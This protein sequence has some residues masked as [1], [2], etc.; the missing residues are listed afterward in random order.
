M[1]LE[2][3]LTRLAWL[4]LVLLLVAGC[5]SQQGLL[6]HD[7]FGNPDSGWGDDSQEMFDR[8]YEDGEY[9]IEVYETDWLAWAT[10]GERLGDIVVQ[11]DARL[12]SGPA[13]GSLGLLC[14][15]NDPDSFYYFAITDDGYAAILLVE[16]GQ[17]ENLS[18]GFVSAAAIQTGGATNRIRAVCAGD[19]LTMYVNDEQVAAAIDGTFRRG[20]VGLAVSSGPEGDV[21]VHFDNLTVRAAQE[22]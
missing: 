6:Y 16:E 18:G 15:Y 9:F 14:R 19:R 12:V 17:V 21:R 22:E 3:T 7:R 20:D 11:A 2:R 13:D 5:S 8:G 1:Q 10:P 4:I